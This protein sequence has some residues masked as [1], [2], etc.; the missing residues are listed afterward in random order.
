M[1]DK[2][3]FIGKKK[4]QAFAKVEE[5][6]EL[7]TTL[8]NALKSNDEPSFFKALSSLGGISSDK[9]MQGI[10]Q[11]DNT[12]L[13]DLG[14]KINARI[15]T[16]SK[17]AKF[18]QEAVK[19]S[20]RLSQSFTILGKTYSKHKVAIIVSIIIA[21]IALFIYFK[22]KLTK[23][24]TSVETIMDSFQKISKVDE[25]LHEAVDVQRIGINLSVAGICV[26][27]LVMFA[28]LHLVVD[29]QT[30]SDS[31]VKRVKTAMAVFVFSMI[32][33]LSASAG[34]AVLKFFKT[35]VFGAK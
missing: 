5:N 27:T 22:K 20:D 10:D 23:Q 18:Y 19:L 34:P 2:T 6:R 32:S 9:L 33:L 28:Q 30:A 11:E 29:K 15:K 14:N 25:K 16:D 24:E 17:V 21:G 1:K 8:V 3:S 26:S 12:F 35:K 7:I 31:D 4:E 13:A